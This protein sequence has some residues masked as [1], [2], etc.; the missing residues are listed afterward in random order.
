VEVDGAGWTVVKARSAST[1]PSISPES[2]SITA[3][4]GRGGAQGDREAT[5]R[6]VEGQLAS[7]IA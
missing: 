3:T 7:Q 4:I 1:S 2:R 5:N 6:D